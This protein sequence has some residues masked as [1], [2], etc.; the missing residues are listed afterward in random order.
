MSSR[1]WRVRMK[2]HDQFVMGLPALPGKPCTA[3]LSARCPSQWHMEPQL[4]VGPVAGLPPTSN[5]RAL[6]CLT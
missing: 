5:M 3:P 4:A 1:A 6:A 2:P